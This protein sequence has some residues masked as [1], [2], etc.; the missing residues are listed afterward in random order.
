MQYDSAP[1]D[2][3]RSLQSF[4][5]SFLGLR[6]EVDFSRGLVDR[7]REVSI[8]GEAEKIIPTKVDLYVFMVLGRRT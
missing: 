4:I 1:S 3:I 7:S 5:F 6:N 8:D 2:L